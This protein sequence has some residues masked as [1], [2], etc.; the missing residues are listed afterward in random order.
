MKEAL[1]IGNIDKIG[2][3]LDFGWQQKKLM[4][5]GISNPNIDLIYET[6]LNAGAT[7]GKIS[8]A[9]GGGF[10]LCFAP[11]NNRYNVI[12]ELNKLGGRT[13]PYRFV[14]HGLTTWKI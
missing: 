6:A 4:A 5:E 11:I 2:D 1:L 14:K 12:K 3:I 10:M 13:M 8:G 7:G 9:G